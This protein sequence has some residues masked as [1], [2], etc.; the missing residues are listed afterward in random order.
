[1]W[2]GISHDLLNYRSAAATILLS[3]NTLVAQNTSSEFINPYMS[4]IVQTDFS[5]AATSILVSVLDTPMARPPTPTE[6]GVSN[7]RQTPIGSRIYQKHVAANEDCEL[8]TPASV[9]FWS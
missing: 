8:H 6:I 3:L 9:I 4:T 7:S 1:M 2:S 5:D